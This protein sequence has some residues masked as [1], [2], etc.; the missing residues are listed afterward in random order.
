MGAINKEAESVYTKLNNRPTTTT[1]RNEQ[2]MTKR[3]NFQVEPNII[4]D[5]SCTYTESTTI[6][7]INTVPTTDKT[8]K[9][10]T[11]KT[12]ILITTVNSTIIKSSIYSETN[13][14]KDN[15]NNNINI[16]PKI[17]QI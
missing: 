9:N 17:A 4:Q 8:D 5:K 7:N 6:K 2:I 12:P 11:T 15:P 1:I 16:K 3:P 14:I 10:I 13:I